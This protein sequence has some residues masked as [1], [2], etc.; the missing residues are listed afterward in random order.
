MR[1]A[2][3]GMRTNAAPFRRP[4]ACRKDSRS[5]DQGGTES[6]NVLPRA[7]IGGAQVGVF[8]LGTGPVAEFGDAAFDWIKV[9]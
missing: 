7:R 8:A 1:A 4:T 3:S 9:E 5:R 2:D 6:A